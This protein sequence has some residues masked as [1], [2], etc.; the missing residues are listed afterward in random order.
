MGSDFPSHGAPLRFSQH[1][2]YAWGSSVHMNAG[3]EVPVRREAGSSLDCGEAMDITGVEVVKFQAAIGGHRRVQDVDTLRPQC[4]M[5]ENRR[6]QRT[7]GRPHPQFRR[8]RPP[9]TQVMSL[10]SS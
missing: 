10:A 3:C 9:R 2:A 6:P 1:P 8:R 4:P 5:W 7:L